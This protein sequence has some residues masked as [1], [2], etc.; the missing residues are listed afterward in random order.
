MTA[1]T[2]H[3]D[4]VPSHPLRSFYPP[5]EPRATGMLDVGDGQQI[6]WEECGNPDGIP[7]AFLHGGPGGGCSPA[8]RQVFDPERYRIILFDQRGCGRS[9]PH[10]WEPEADLS[11]NTT[12]HLVEDMERLRTHLGVDR[13]L[14]FGG[15][16]GSTL[17]LAYA[18]TYPQ[19]VLALV[20]RGIF[21]LRKRE[22]DWYYEAG[23]ADMVWPDE[24]EHYVAAAGEDVEPGGY[25]ERY[26]EL[27]SHPDPAVH[28]PAG[29]AWTTWE[30]ATSTLLRDQAHLDEVQDPSYAVTFARIE[31]HFFYHQ[32]WMRDGQLIQGAR[33]LAEHHIPGVIVQGRYDMCCPIGTAWALHRAWPEAE[34]RISPTAG[35]AFSEPETLSALIEATDFFATQ[36]SQSFDGAHSRETSGQAS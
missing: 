4:G 16:W 34:L 26:H 8:H 35:H 3:D 15:S 12:W 24:W 10:A 32:G 31:N 30:A 21:T 25:I 18:Q 20:L 27:L 14:V 22:L 6:Y 13:W 33:L 17:A 2:V 5:I 1:L 9:L 11:T 29:I 23:G 7:A 28:G 19:R 36:L